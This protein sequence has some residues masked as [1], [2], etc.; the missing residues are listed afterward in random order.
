SLL[1]ILIFVPALYCLT[2]EI[3]IAGKTHASFDAANKAPA[4][5]TPEASPAVSVEVVAGSDEQAPA[6]LSVMDIGG[7]TRQLKLVAA[8]GKPPL[9]SYFGEDDAGNIYE[10]TAP[11]ASQAAPKKPASHA[12]RHEKADA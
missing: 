5:T 8:P 6:I 1:L 3:D 9:A 2:G 11:P 10:F 7:T 12:V 4:P